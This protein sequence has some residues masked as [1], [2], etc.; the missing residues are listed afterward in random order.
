MYFLSYYVLSEIQ[1]IIISDPLPQ[2]GR[3]YPNTKGLMY[4]TYNFA[5]TGPKR[6]GMCYEGTLYNWTDTE[7]DVACR[8]SGYNGGLQLGRMQIH[9]RDH[10]ILTNMRCTGSEF[11]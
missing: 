8:Q 1:D 7:A 9:Y 3:T 10:H 6:A 5:A 2:N 4:V 11:L